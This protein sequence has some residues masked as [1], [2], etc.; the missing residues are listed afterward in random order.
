MYFESIYFMGGLPDILEQFRTE[1]NQLIQAKK[2][3]NISISFDNLINSLPETLNAQVEGS[4]NYYK[5]IFEHSLSGFGI[6]NLNGDII[7]CN[8]ALLKIL[9]FD[10]LETFKKHNIKEFYGDLTERESLTQELNEK[11]FVKEF[12]LIVKT[13]DNRN[14]TALVNVNLLPDGD[15]DNIVIVNFKD[16]SERLKFQKELIESEKYLE[17]IFN[18][19]NSGILLIDPETHLIEDVNTS[20]LKM[21]DYQKDQ[22]VGKECFEFICPSEKG[23]CPITDRHE[24]INDSTQVLITKDGDQKFILKSVRKIKIKGKPYLLETFTDINAQKEAERELKLLNEELELRI[25]ERTKELKKSEEK[26]RRLSELSPSAI[27]IQRGNKYFYVN[28]A[29]TEITGFNATEIKNTGPFDIIHPDM[30]ETAKQLSKNQLREDGAKLR[31]ELKIITKD[32]KIKWLDISLTRFKYEDKDASFAIC[33]DITSIR[34]I[35]NELKKSES[36][37]RG[38]VENLKQEYFFYRH[39]LDGFFEYISPSIKNILGYDPVDFKAHYTKYL[40]TNPMNEIARQKTEL[41]IKGI[42]QLPYEL[43]IY[44]IQKNTHVLKISETPIVNPEGNVLAVEGIAHDITSKK[45]AEQVIND[46]LEEIRITNEEIKSI[47]EELHAVNDDLEARLKEIDILNKELN[48]SK[49]KYETLVNNIPGIV[50]RCRIDKEWTMEYISD[51][52]ELLTGYKASD[53]ILSNTRSYTSIIHP[54]DI[55]LVERAIEE[56]VE[57]S[58]S[59]SIEYRIIN[60]KGEIL[61]VFER[62]QM[63]TKGKKKLLNGV[64]IDIS[65]KKEVEEKLEQERKFSTNIIKGTPSII[66]GINTDGTTNYINPAGEQITGY[67]SEELIGK[68]WWKVFYPGDEYRQ[69]EKLFKEFEKGDVKNYEMTLTT[70]NGKKRTVTWNSINHYDEEGN[71]L[72]VIGFGNDITEQNKAYQALQESEELYQRLVNNQGEGIGIVDL[73]ETFTFANPAAHKIFGVPAGSLIGQNLNDFLTDEFILPIQDQTNN[74]RKG[75]TSSY[76]IEIMRPD[77]TIRCILVT[78]SP[79]YNK[80]QEVIGVFAVFRDIT[81]RKN[82]E[83]ILFKSEKELRKLNAQKDKFFSIIAH[84]L[85][86]P[87]SNFV[88]VSE[89]LTMNYEHMPDDK[90]SLLFNDMNTLANNTFKLLD[91]LLMW[92]RSQ[93]G[94]INVAMQDVKVYNIVEDVRSLYNENIKDKELKLVNKIPNTLKIKTDYNITHTVIRNLINNAIKFTPSGGNIVVQISS[95]KSATKN[96]TISVKDSGI[97][98]PKDKISRLFDLDDDYTTLGTEKEKGTGLGLILCKEL[99]EKTG[100]NIWVE[101]KIDKGTTFYFTLRR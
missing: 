48:F 69:V 13:N 12:K 63:F 32:Q 98:I 51:E 50:F 33:N 60:S 80:N 42:Q 8:P 24:K 79:E 95:L 57:Q 56:N 34:K 2:Y 44:D 46:Q 77:K 35:Q 99:I 67:K 82:A 20:A 26:F 31:Y 90:M 94:H 81:E 68:N 9:G 84:D 86:S 37:Y 21:I 11:G 19:V 70:K 30:K 78:A 18:S 93:L 62:G 5:K 40:T 88:Q 100:G 91:N 96:P 59:Y 53:F 101:S 85:R 74:R 28:P 36:K 92:S 89:L 72:E 6:A 10:N 29:W 22:V 54:D 39:N 61:W 38:L 41:A 27:S 15:H 7:D 52:V 71:I 75:M 4:A 14:I 58:N 49:T 65:D 45:K 16:I 25:I 55:T 43:E 64:I 66:C 3:S 1:L 47:N 97:G 76:E 83:E 17:L 73:N 23:K 87:V